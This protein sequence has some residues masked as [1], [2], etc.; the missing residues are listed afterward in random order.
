MVTILEN[1]SEE[2]TPSAERSVRKVASISLLGTSIEWYDFFLYGAAAATVF[3]S[4]FFSGSLPPMVALM[5]AFATFAV[6]FVAR[7]VGG[8]VFGHFGDK[9]GRK[10]TLVTAL[11]MMGLATTLIGL[12]PGYATIGALA[13]LALIVLRFVQ[14]LA[15]GG[16]WAGAMLIVTESAPA[17]R[18]GFYGSFAQAGAPLGVILANF[19]LLIASATLTE[20]QFTTWGWRVPFLL[21]VLLVGV[22][23]Y[24]Q[25]RLEET[26]SFKRVQQLSERR[27]KE[28]EISG[29]VRSRSPVLQVLRSHPKQILLAAGAFISVQVSFYILVA[30]VIAYGEN[31]AGLSV[32]RD[33][34]LAGVLIGALI[35]AP[36]VFISGAVSDR[37]GRRKIFMAGAALL[38]LWSFALFPL[39]DT[40]SLLWISLGIGVAQIFVAMMYGPQAAFFAELF[41]TEVRYSGASLGY[42]IGAIVGG[43][44]A[45]LAATAL[46][47]NYGSGF[48]ISVY[49]AIASL[50]SLIAVSMLHETYKTDIHPPIQA[51]LESDAA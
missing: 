39:I 29:V 2:L 40:G 35:M 50:I 24:V 1:T 6:G 46:L 28:A 32:S 21:S 36:A 37:F 13:P 34:M 17:H 19:A 49:M 30:F 38:G 15:I 5:A 8:I 42:Q 20:E 31:R 14:G 47:A 41:T 51:D 4:V 43:A 45:P 7:P 16:Q 3:P 27:A 10:G 26:E 18:R 44:A 11:V 25:L 23:L 33:T 12:L 48:A 9:L 22:A